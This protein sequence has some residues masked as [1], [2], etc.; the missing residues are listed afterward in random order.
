[1]Y[2]Q[3]SSHGLRRG[4]LA[5]ALC[6]AAGLAQA[7]VAVIV[8]AKSTAANLSKEQV[9]DIFQGKITA[10]PSGGAANPVDQAEASPLRDEF[11]TKAVGKSAAQMKSYW[12]KLA[13]TGKGTP[14]KEFPSSA[15]VKKA[16]AADPALIGYVEK[17][18][19]DGSV[20]V[21]FAAP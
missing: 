16:I 21:L 8:S 20:K 1:M 11:Y 7:E 4:L 3:R 14:P 13:F 6:V 19:V 10:F 15:E 5:A 9:A 18:A 2:Q 17:T 12:S